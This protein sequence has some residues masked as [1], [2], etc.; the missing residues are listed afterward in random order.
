M[1][2][3]RMALRVLV[4]LMASVV[5]VILIAQSADIPGALRAIVSVD[6]RWLIAP[7]IVLIVQMWSRSL[8]WAIILS[9]IA[10]RRVPAARA[11][12]PLAAGYLGNAVLPARLGEVLRILFAVR[13]VGVTA[14]ASTASVVVE[15]AVDLL[16][17]L[18]VAAAAYGVV[19]GVGVVPLVLVLGALAAMALVLRSGSWIAARLPKAIPARILDV[20]QR[21][22]L[23]FGAVRPAVLGRAWAVGLATWSFDALVMWFAARALGIEL[24]P[25]VAILIASGAALGA[26]LP[27]ASGALGTYELGAVAAAG[28]IGV[29]ADAALQ[30]ALLG[31]LLALG[32]MVTL[33]A[34][35]IVVMSLAPGRAPAPA[36]EPVTAP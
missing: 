15:R 25:A 21:L 28:L 29:S 27:A 22:L 7:L 34:I 1:K 20:V 13:W 17:L 35:G 6:A 18:T 4:G 19:A 26:A 2:H 8:R 36:P 11:F 23:A 31:H 14:T 32:T 5:A 3:G 33:G 10:H 9:A 24:S 30:V 16:A 12:W